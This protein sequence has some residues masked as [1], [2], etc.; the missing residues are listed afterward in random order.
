MHRRRLTYHLMKRIVYARQ[1]TT[2]AQMADASVVKQQLYLKGDEA[3][4]SCL[5]EFLAS[6]RLASSHNC[7]AIPGASGPTQQSLPTCSKV[8]TPLVPSAYG[9]NADIRKRQQ[10]SSH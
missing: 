3:P 2:T 1:T 5:L 4:R 6:N 9:K 7:K 10:S 8:S